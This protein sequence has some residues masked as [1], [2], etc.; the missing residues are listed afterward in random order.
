MLAI[1]STDII[2]IF[3]KGRRSKSRS[4]SSTSGR[5]GKGFVEPNKRLFVSGLST[6]V[7]LAR[8]VGD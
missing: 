3:M 7:L 4:S 1:L 6:E 5:Y 8:Y 2:L